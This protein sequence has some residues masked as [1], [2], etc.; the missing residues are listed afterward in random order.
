[1]SKTPIR[2]ATRNEL[3]P[4]IRTIQ[5]PVADPGDGQGAWEMDEIPH[6]TNKV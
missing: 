4:A 6:S 2:H 1:M 5:T 3:A